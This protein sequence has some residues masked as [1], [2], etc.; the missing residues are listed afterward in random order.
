M[1]ETYAIIRD[2]GREMKV[3]EGETFLVDLRSVEAGEEITFPDVL[4]VSSSGDVTIGRPTVEGASVVGE[5]KGQVAMEKLY[6]YKFKR[7]KG[8]HRKIGHRQKM[9][10]VVV[11][12]IQTAG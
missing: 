2:S 8:Y 6:P 11:R 9:L 7:R 4:L 3:A 5:V 10:E 1:S 12:S